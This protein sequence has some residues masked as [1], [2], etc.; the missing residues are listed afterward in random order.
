MAF[1]SGV[2]KRVSRFGLLGS[3][4]YARRLDIYSVAVRFPVQAFLLLP[5]HVSKAKWS[6]HCLSALGPIILK[7]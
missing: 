1:V 3:L 2:F 7:L 4:L 6:F 5:F